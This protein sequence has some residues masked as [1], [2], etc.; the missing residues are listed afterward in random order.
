VNWHH[1]RMFGA[2]SASTC[3]RSVPW[4]DILFKSALPAVGS[5]SYK[6]YH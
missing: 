3:L 1:R 2:A 4:L 6:P 5:P